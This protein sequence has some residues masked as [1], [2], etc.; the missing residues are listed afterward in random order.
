MYMYYNL[1]FC[2]FRSQ[3]SDIISEILIYFY[4]IKHIFITCFYNLNSFIN[5]ANVMSG[6]YIHIPFCGSKCSYCDFYSIVASPL[7]GD[8][9]KAIEK[10]IDLRYSEINFD[11]LRTIYIGG[12]TPSII[13]DKI[14]AP[15]LTNISDK[16]CKSPL[17]E[18]TVEMNPDDVTEKKVNMFKK[19]GCN[20]VSIGVQSMV[21]SELR[22]I[23]RRHSSQK[24]V[25]SVSIFRDC[26]IDNISIDLMFGLPLQT[27]DTLRYSI[28]KI[29]DLS[30]MHISCYGL[31]Y[32]LDTLLYRMR[33]DGMIKEID[34]DT[35]IKMYSIVSESLRNAGFEHYEISNYAKPGYRSLHNSSYW[36]G[37]PYVGIGP[38][39]HSYDGNCI[40]RYN[41]NDVRKYIKTLS[42]CEI[43]Y[44]EEVESKKDI[45]NDYIL[46][47]LRTS[48]GIQRQL[49]EDK[50][51][52]DAWSLLVSK[53][54][55]RVE[56]G[57]VELTDERLVLTEI[58]FLTSDDIISDL[59]IE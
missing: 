41:P 53:T 31:M 48:Q 30:P 37:T 8:F 44:V 7:H 39:A 40:R 36:N 54:H 52:A 18:F 11:F 34:E 32:E 42:N 24:V 29:L 47:R 14:L 21:D 17:D 33:N 12:G 13:N 57:A 16:L 4:V 59:F 2:Y 50:F 23:S 20:R 1:Y 5:F 27:I 49:Y 58:G 55:R 10:E 28:D 43:F 45:H 51:G 6:L 46:T 3:F 19:A 56:S 15:F 9:I 26:G 38:S 35:Y 25:D 22:A